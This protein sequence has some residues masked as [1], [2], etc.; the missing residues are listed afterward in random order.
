MEVIWLAMLHCASHMPV[1]FM[2]AADHWL[3]LLHL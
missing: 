2:G 1:D 3:G